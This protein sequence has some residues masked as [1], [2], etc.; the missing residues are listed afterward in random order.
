MYVCMYVF[1]LR[2]TLPRYTLTN[3]P[4]SRK[5]GL[6]VTSKTVAVPAGNSTSDRPVYCLVTILTEL[7]RLERRNNTVTEKFKLTVAITTND[8]QCGF[9]AHP[10]TLSNI[11]K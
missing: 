4:V 5:A 11:R 9:P 2:P 3:K 7:S 6:E 10:P 8:G 1:T